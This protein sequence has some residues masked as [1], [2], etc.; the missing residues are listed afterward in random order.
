MYVHSL[1][2]VL[3]VVWTVWTAVVYTRYRLS[4]LV[5]IH[6]G[7]NNFEQSTRGTLM[8][9]AVLY[10][11]GII[12]HV[13][14]CFWAPCRYVRRSSGVWCP[15][16]EMTFRFPSKAAPGEMMTSVLAPIIDST[17]SNMRRFLK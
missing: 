9:T 17:T 1:A 5:S 16:K 6:L 12:Q 13:Y 2:V 14:P 8:Q 3:T 7:T 10:W 4:S 11:P 15:A